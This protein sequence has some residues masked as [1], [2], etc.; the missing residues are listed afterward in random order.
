MLCLASLDVLKIVVKHVA[1]MTQGYRGITSR[2]HLPM[3]SR[4]NTI[5][6]G[7]V[8]PTLGLKCLSINTGPAAAFVHV[9]M[10]HAKLHWLVSRFLK[11]QF[12]TMKKQERA[13][14]QTDPQTDPQTNTSAKVDW[15]DR[16]RVNGC[17][18]A[19][20]AEQVG[21]KRNS[22]VSSV[23]CVWLGVYFELHWRGVRKLCKYLQYHW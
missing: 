18:L 14:R 20:Y 2:N 9:C 22:L 15:E 11:S 8:E 10:C 19:R 4:I 23:L 5:T 16:G 1:Y 17:Q 12:I 13:P 3:A 6:K 21:E 7:I